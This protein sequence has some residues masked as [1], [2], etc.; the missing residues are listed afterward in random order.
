MCNLYSVTTNQEALR[1]LFK[2]TLDSAGNMPASFS[3]FPDHEAPIVRRHE[4]GRELI[5]ARW[6]LPN[7]D[8]GGLNTNIR[9]PDY[10]N[11]RPWV[12]PLNPTND[13]FVSTQH[14]C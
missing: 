12:D 1:N 11:W 7:P 13:D 4:S 3:V 10:R 14:R 9:N 2:V 8:H 5:K 6:G